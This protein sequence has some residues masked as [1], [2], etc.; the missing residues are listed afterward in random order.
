MLT[1]DWTIEKLHTRWE[2]YRNAACMGGILAS[3]P[4]ALITVLLTKTAV[5]KPEVSYG[6]CGGVVMVEQTIPI[7][8]VALG[9]LMGAVLGVALSRYQALF[10]RSSRE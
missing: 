7:E 6:W 2:R 3:I 5:H 10:R 9:V 4:S 8:F 1:I